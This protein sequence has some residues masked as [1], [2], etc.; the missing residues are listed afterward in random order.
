M[1]KGKY[2]PEELSFSPADPVCEFERV[3]YWTKKLNE[4]L[5]PVG[6]VFRRATLCIGESGTYYL[7]SDVGV[8]LAGETL[9]D[10]MNCLIAAS[11]KPTEVLPAPERE[12]RRELTV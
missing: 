2:R 8:Y 6:A 7:I 9:L 3:S 11:T 12:W 5:C 1:L 4:V 10:C